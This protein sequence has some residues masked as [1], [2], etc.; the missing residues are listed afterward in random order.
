MSV[1]CF[2]NFRRFLNEFRNYLLPLLGST[3][4]EKVL[5]DSRGVMTKSY[6]KYATFDAGDHRLDGALTNLSR[7]FPISYFVP[8]LLQLL[9]LQVK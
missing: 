9:N 6:F 5:D 3:V 1:R 4:L 2:T 7:S 8:V